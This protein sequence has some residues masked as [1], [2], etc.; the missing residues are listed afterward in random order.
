M[1]KHTK[2]LALAIFAVVSLFFVTASMAQTNTTGEVVG[3][4]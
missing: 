4:V 3:V 2:F 1:K